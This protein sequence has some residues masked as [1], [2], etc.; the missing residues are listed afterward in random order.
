M[1]FLNKTYDQG[2]VFSLEVIG[3][4]EKVEGLTM[5]AKVKVMP[6]AEGRIDY[7]PNPE[8]F[9]SI[10]KL[11]KG[12]KKLEYED[13]VQDLTKNTGSSRVKFVE[14]FLCK[15]YAILAVWKQ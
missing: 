10:T 12:L 11:L 1:G 9:E 15:R 6:N 5:N 8:S 7:N 2:E 3:W 14:Y 4:G 13:F